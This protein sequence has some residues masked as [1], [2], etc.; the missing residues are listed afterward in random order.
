MGQLQNSCSLHERSGYTH[1]VMKR[2]Y[3]ADPGE[4]C[5]SVFQRRACGADVMER[6]LGAG[7]GS[8]YGFIGH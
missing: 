7:G 2:D 4:K 1:Y 5:S 6:V 8:G 3:C